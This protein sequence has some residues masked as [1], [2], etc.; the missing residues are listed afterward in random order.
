MITRHGTFGT[1]RSQRPLGTVAGKLA[2]DV[3]A[4]TSIERRSMDAPAPYFRWGFIQISLSNLVVI[5]V[6]LL[7]FVLALA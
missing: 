3:A 2:D 6:M 4:R 1:G 7:I 5:L